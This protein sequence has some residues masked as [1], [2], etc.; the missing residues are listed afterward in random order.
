MSS[1]HITAWTTLFGSS[2]NNQSTDLVIGSDGSIYISGTTRGNLNGQLNSG[3]DDAFVSKFNNDGEVQ[4][5]RLLGTSEDDKGNSISIGSDGSI[6]IIGSTEGDLDGETNLEGGSDV[7][8]TKFNS[9]GIKQW[10]KLVGVRG[11]YSGTGRLGIDIANDDSIYITGNTLRD[12]DGE[13]NNG[14]YDTFI[15]KFNSDGDKQWSKLL[16]TSYWEFGQDISVGSDGSIYLTGSTE[17]DL[18]GEVNNGSGDIFISKFNSDGDKE[19]TKL[20]GTSEDDEGQAIT[21]DNKGFIYVLGETRGDLDGETNTGG[22]DVFIS[23]YDSSGEKQWTR[24]LGSKN[25]DYA[26]SLI[27]GSDGSIYLTG[28]SSVNPWNDFDGQSGNYGD[29]VY[30]SKF[31]SNGNKQWTSLLGTSETDIGNSISIG[32]DDSIYVTGYT[33]GDLNGL[34]NSGGNDAFLIKLAETSSP[35]GISLSS[36]IFDENIDFEYRFDGA[37]CFDVLEHLDPKDSEQFFEKCKSYLTKNGI[38]II[39]VP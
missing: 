2:F 4:W 12:L 27:T 20:L 8:I 11:S 17:G 21:I 39:G 14:S 5:T 29:D 38:F 22:Q 1:N 36:S 15:S 37:I 23:Q 9:N 10:T 13:V 3:L 25:W 35:T 18:D 24:L 30:I 7:F 6:Y 33:E 32:D 31:S 28:F 16:G 26:T 19:W 34:S